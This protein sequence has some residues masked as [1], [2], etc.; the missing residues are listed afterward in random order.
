[1]EIK[2]MVNAVY[3]HLVA[4]LI[5]GVIF[6]G[7]VVILPS[8]SFQ[9]LKVVDQ[10]QLRNTAL[11]LFNAMFLDPGEPTNWGSMRPFYLNDPRIER[12]GLGSVRDS[13]FYVL[14]P[15]KV[16]RLVVNNPLNYC[17]YDRTREL[18]QLQ[19]YGFTLKIIP[20]FNITFT[21]TSVVGNTLTYQANVTYL[22]GSPIPNA[23]A[24]S[25][26]VVSKDN[27]Y[28]NITKS[29]PFGSNAMGIVE[30]SVELDV[31]DPDYHVVILHVTVADVATLVVTSKK[32]TNNTIARI[33]LVY[34]D[35]ILTSWK[36][37]P[38]YNVPP[39]E[40][41]WIMDILAF[42]SD[43]MMWHLLDEGKVSENK[44]NTGSGEF[45]RWSRPFI[46]IHDFEPVIMVFNF[47]AVDDEGNGR[48]QV[49]ITVAYPD[50]LGTNIFEYGGYPRR[51]DLATATV[52]RNVIISGMTYTSELT[53]W[54][55]SL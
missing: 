44:F 11:N 21:G 41:V 26:A 46:G 36:D 52:H 37:P 22:D 54:K 33:N 38:N 19:D 15:D 50:L 1:V 42:D 24:Y 45:E 34:D 13:T 23:L 18:L 12:F 29:G 35:L 25:T 32:E 2:R 31:T 4:I 43:G 17:Q 10:Q 27:D 55:E 47:W 3:D 51:S 8:M 40:N 16:Q 39:S 9:N 48:Q 14:D 28:F 49:M 7:A 20:P 6:I 53:V 5:V 30:G